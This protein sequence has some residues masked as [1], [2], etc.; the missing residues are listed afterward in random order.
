MYETVLGRIDAISASLGLVR[1][2]QRVRPGHNPWGYSGGQETSLKGEKAQ[3]EL[4]KKAAES[5]VES[6]ET[7]FTMVEK[8][9]VERT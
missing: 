2:S 1:E 4:D 6:A 5:D 7:T 8:T 9:E 3:D